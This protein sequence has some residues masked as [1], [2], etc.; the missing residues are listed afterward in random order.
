VGRFGYW[1]RQWVRD[2]TI[3]GRPGIVVE[4]AH[5][6]FP[7]AQELS[8]PYGLN[9]GA[10][11]DGH[12][13][14]GPNC[15]TWKCRTWNSMTWNC[16]TWQISIYF[17]KFY[18]IFTVNC[19]LAAALLTRIDSILLNFS[20]F[21]YCDAD[22][23]AM[24]LC[25]VSGV[26]WTSNN[27]NDINMLLAQITPL[28]DLSRVAYHWIFFSNHSIITLHSSIAATSASQYKKKN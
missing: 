16:K 15:R 23:A 26:I 11:N 25:N 2:Y 4:V 5:V 1:I 9:G 20:F 10:G 24:E 3:K 27:T 7:L 21:L 18:A 12:E 17:G 14:D 28:A 22:V 13:N 8:T 19:S 6:V